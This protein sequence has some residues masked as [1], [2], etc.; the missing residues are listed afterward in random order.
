VLRTVGDAGA[1]LARARATTGLPAGAAAAL[2]DALVGE[3]AAA[4]RGQ[5]LVPPGSGA[6]DAGAERV[7]RLLE[8][9]GLR[10]PTPHQLG[11]AAGLD[12]AALRAALGR[13]RAAGRA[14]PAGELWF[15]AG[16]L[17]VATDQA[18]AA[19]AERPLRVSELRDLWGVGRRN[20]LALVAH[21]DATGVTVRRGDERI[22]RGAGRVAG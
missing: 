3:G 13:L 11:E 12:A 7:A 9:G 8:E 19:L 5:R 17:A 14:A 2:V 22:L 6:L 18:R 10:P 20:A 16:A 4:V 15:D 21:L 1:P